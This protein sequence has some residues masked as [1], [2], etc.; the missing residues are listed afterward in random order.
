MP[1]FHNIYY[2]ITRN[3]TSPAPSLC[4][5]GEFNWFDVTLVSDED[6]IASPWATLPHVVMICMSGV[7]TIDDFR[8]LLFDINQG[9]LCPSQSHNGACR[10]IVG[11]VSKLKELNFARFLAHYSAHHG[12]FPFTLPDDED[13]FERVSNLI[14]KGLGK[15]ASD[16]FKRARDGADDFGTGRSINMFTIEHMFAEF[17]GSMILKELQG[18]PTVYGCKLES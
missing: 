13:A 7:G 10:E 12:Q 16:I 14:Q 5:M 9:N 15:R 8:R 6:I 2:R 18:K 3:P 17:P 1:E 11:Y 4:E